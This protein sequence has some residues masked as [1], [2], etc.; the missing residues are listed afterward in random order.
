MSDL[1]RPFEVAIPEAALEDLR[2]R[3]N[4]TRWPD[5]ETPDDWSQGIPLS[6]MQEICQYWADG[7]DWRRCEGVL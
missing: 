7:Y 5:A 6:Y 1:I 3:L 2:R 4:A